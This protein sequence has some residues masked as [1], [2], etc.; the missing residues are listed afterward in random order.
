[1]TPQHQQLGDKLL[2]LPGRRWDGTSWAWST[3]LPDDAEQSGRT[4]RGHRTTANARKSTCTALTTTKPS[5][6]LTSWL[7]VRQMRRQQ[8]NAKSAA[9]PADPGRAWRTHVR[10]NDEDLI[11]RERNL[12]IMFA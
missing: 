5:L 9:I 1:M 10:H 4:A 3:P 12:S 2:R 7:R 11:P 8:Q 6:P